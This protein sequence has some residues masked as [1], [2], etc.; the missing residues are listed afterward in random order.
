MVQPRIHHTKCEHT[1]ERCKHYGPF[2]KKHPELQVYG[3]LYNIP[4]SVLVNYV[5]VKKLPSADLLETEEWRR[6]LVYAIKKKVILLEMY[7]TNGIHSKDF[8]KQTQYHAIVSDGLTRARLFYDQ[9]KKNV[10]ARFCR[11]WTEHY[12][13]QLGTQDIQEER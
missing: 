2:L 1:S 12:V 3:K 13:Y 7:T 10:K 8:H 11:G 6:L 4:A 5:D 9:H